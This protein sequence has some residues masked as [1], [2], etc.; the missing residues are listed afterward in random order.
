MLMPPHVIWT[1]R[2][3]QR[4]ASALQSGQETTEATG[5]PTG[6][7]NW[8]QNAF[9]DAI[10]VIVLNYY[11]GFKNRKGEHILRVDVHRQGTANT[12]VVKLAR[13]ERLAQERHAWIQCTLN[14]TNPV[15]MRLLAVPDPQVEGRLCAIVYQDAEAHIGSESTLWLE[16]A[17]QNCVRFNRPTLPSI[18]RVLHDVYTQTRRLYESASLKLAKNVGIETMPSRERPNHRHL[19]FN[20]LN[21]WNKPAEMSIRRRVNAAFSIGFSQFLDPVDYFHFLDGEQKKANVL[22][23]QFR[24]LSHGDLHGRNLLVGMDD[25]EEAGFPSL[26]DYEHINEDN[27]VGWDF[28]EM[29]TELKI[30]CYDRVFAD[31]EGTKLTQSIQEFEWRL[32]DA[33]K[34]AHDTRHWPI[35]REAASPED[36]LFAILLAIRQEAFD[37]LSRPRAG[38]IQWLHEYFFLLGAYALNTVRYDNQTPLQRMA[39]YIS[40]GVAAAFW[41]KLRGL[42]PAPPADPEILKDWPCSGYRIPLEMAYAW[43]RGTED[44]RRRAE[45]LL[46]SLI[47]RFPSALHVW[48]ER[49]FNHARQKR[50]TEAIK[51]LQRIHET[52]D[53]AMDEDTYGLWGRCHKETGDWYLESGFK[54]VQGSERQRSAFEEAE[55]AYGLAIERYQQAFRVM[56]G[57]FPGI[58][59]ATLLFLRAGLNARLG[60]LAEVEALRKESHDLAEKLYQMKLQR[61]LPDDDIWTRATQAE[62]ALLCGNFIYAAE[63]YHAALARDN[64]RE[65]HLESMGSQIRRLIEAYRLLGEKV[66]RE[67]FAIVPELLAYFPT[68]DFK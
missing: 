66:P 27:L 19:L 51:M 68:E 9:S 62:A 23:D 3:E 7:H 64:R 46:D 11:I 41:E 55:E 15:F 10:D 37:T 34:H 5:S 47:D 1:R 57:F 24:G 40:A 29:E 6:L 22:P 59:L 61:K 36:R 52:F 32:A 63:R 44:E 60:R 38:S 18:L 33:T 16:T 12:Y 25:R 8:L 30:R 26:F 50:F 20:S 35:D 28:V 67:P 65:H 56:A 49:A 14:D 58:N 42:R 43:N 39:A 54:Y 21:S 31:C 45:P 48:Y 17:V 4:Y 53:D 13:H 2:A